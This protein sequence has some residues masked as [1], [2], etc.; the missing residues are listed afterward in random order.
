MA[1][2]LA[3]PEAGRQAAHPAAHRAKSAWSGGGIAE[4]GAEAGVPRDAFL[5]VLLHGPV[6]AG[7]FPGMGDLGHFSGGSERL[8]EVELRK[9]Y[10]L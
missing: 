3:Q 8:T 1:G 4:P 5:A 7:A 9:W 6:R 10:F 2:G